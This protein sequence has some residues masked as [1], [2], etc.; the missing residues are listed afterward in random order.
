MV[1]R[2]I[3]TTLLIGV[4]AIPSFF[5]TA[6]A[7]ESESRTEIA[8]PYISTVTCSCY[9]TKS[10]G[11]K[12]HSGDFHD[13]CPNDDLI[14]GA[15]SCENTNNARTALVKCDNAG[16]KDTYVYER[17]ASGETKTDYQTVTGSGYPADAHINPINT[18]VPVC[19]RHE[20]ATPVSNGSSTGRLHIRNYQ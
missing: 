6:V 11:I 19:V 1:K 4:I 8:T 7:I 9:T 3:I 10:S 17:D 20:V 15:Y 13:T 18:Y 2:K 16:Y 14:T 5:V 12:D